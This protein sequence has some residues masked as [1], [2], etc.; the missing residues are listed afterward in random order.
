MTSIE[1]IK[2]RK[3]QEYLVSSRD[4]QSQ[5]QMTSEQR[6]LMEMQAQ[7][8]QIMSTLLS[9]E[10]QERISNIRNIKPDFALQVEVYLVQ[11]FQ[12][13]RLKPPLN[14]E[15]LKSILDQLVKKRELQIIRK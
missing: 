7:I 13:G 10:A 14:D 8:K 2:K 15:Q 9:K 11:L 4:A 1:E 6:Q 3:M 12:A 5:Q